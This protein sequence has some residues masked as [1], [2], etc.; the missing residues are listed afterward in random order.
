MR[1]ATGEIIEAFPVNV[2][3]VGDKTLVSIRPERVEYRSERI[4]AGAHRIEG[5]VLEFI[6][7]G[8]IFRT[9]F[10][11]AGNDQFVMKC[12]NAQGQAKLVPGQ[13]VQL[14]WMT[15]DCRAL[16]AA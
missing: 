13:K 10:R 14:G 5:E 6:Y 16:D 2:G 12:R 9:R 15:Q 11:V 8:D 3:K 1:L 7:M 4:P